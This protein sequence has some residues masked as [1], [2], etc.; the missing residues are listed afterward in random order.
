MAKNARTRNPPQ[1]RPACGSD[2]SSCSLDY[3][4]P[5]QHLGEIESSS[6]VLSICNSQPDG[7]ASLLA[8]IRDTFYGRPHN[9]SVNLKRYQRLSCPMKSTEGIGG[10][11]SERLA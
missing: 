3:L 9:F 5:A 11:L 4:D 2:G 6:L 10:G 7:A 1:G 8:K